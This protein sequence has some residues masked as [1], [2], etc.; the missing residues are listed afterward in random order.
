MAAALWGFVLGVGFLAL[1]F[2]MSNVKIPR[3][4][5]TFGLLAAGA[6]L[7]VI[8]GVLGAKSYRESVNR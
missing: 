4:G 3:D 1:A 8:G 5:A 2:S 6:L 7:A